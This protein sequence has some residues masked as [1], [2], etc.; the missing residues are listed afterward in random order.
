MKK[1]NFI[2]VDDDW[3]SNYL[4]KLT[5]EAF[6]AANHIYST[7]VGEEA[8]EY[9]SNLY[10]NDLRNDDISVFVFLDINMPGM[11]GFD[12][13]DALQKNPDDLF[14]KIKFFLLSSTH[15]RTDL[16]RINN[17]KNVGF[18]EKPLTTEKL[19]ALVLTT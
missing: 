5:L 6:G 3:I 11:D 16:D 10:R 19:E 14:Y 7:T 9:I 4:N 18:I 13:L 8:V 2:L 17:Y 12:V 1:F 15:N